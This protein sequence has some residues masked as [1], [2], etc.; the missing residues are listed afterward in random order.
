M[1]GEAD[2]DCQAAYAF[3]RETKCIVSYQR[4]FL[5]PVESR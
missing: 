5:R 3:A 4:Q 2:P 1:V